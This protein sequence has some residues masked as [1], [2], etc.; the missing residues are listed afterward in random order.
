MNNS[1][2]NSNPQTTIEIPN[3]QITETVYSGS[4]TIVFRGICTNDQLPVVIKLLKNDYPTFSELVQFRNQYTIAKNLH[5][6]L[7]IQTYSLE[8]Y[9]NSYALVM[10][11]F[12]GISL[13]EWGLNRE[14]RPSLSEVLEIAITLCN[15]LEILYRERI[16]HKDIK[17]SNILINPETK[18]VKLI[19][20][21][22]ASLLPKE[23]QILINPNVLEGT[24]AYISPE[25]TG[26]M[27]R[28]IDY[29]TDFYSLGITF[30]KLLTGKLPFE[31]ND[32]MEL[33]HCHLAKIAPSINEINPKIPF[34]LSKIVS[35]LIAKNAESRYQSILG[36]KYD[37][38][39]CLSQLQQTGNIQDFEIARRD[40]SDR[41]LIPDKLYGR[42]TEITELLAA[43]ERVAVGNSEMT[44]VAGFSGIGKTAVVNE[45]HK[46]IVR[47]RGYFIKGK[48]DQFNHNIPFSAF[49]Q[50][51]RDLMGQLLSE[52]DEELA[53]WKA[54]ILAAVGD[55]GQVLIDVIPELEQVISQQS[56]ATEL[57]GSAAQNRF[58]LLFGKFVQLFTT[59][60]HPLVLFLDDLQWADSASLNLLKVLMGKSESGYLLVLGAY[61]DNEVFPAHPLMLTLDEIEQQ[62]ETLNTIVLKPL[63]RTQITHLVADTLVCSLEV[64]DPLGRLICQKTQGNP[65]FTTQFLKGLYE[66]ELIIF[67]SNLGYWQCDLVKVR[68][69][70]L[71]DDVVEFM[72]ERLLKFSNVTREVLKLAACIGNQFSLET[73]AVVY[74]SSEAEVAKALWEPL[75][76]G[77]LLPTNEI[78]KFYQSEKNTAGLSDIKDIKERSPGYKFLHDRVQQAAYSLI[79]E[80]QRQ[81]IHLT[82]G[83]LLQRNASIA[84]Q[85]ELIFEI[86]NQMNM[87]KQLVVVQEQ[88]NNLARLNLIA[89]K[90]SIAAT[91]YNAASRYSEVGI[92]M[93]GLDGWKSQYE[94]TLDLH[95][96]AAE[97]SYLDTKFEKINE[98]AEPVLKYAKKILEKTKIYEIQI[99][100]HSAQ[101]NIK[102]SAETGLKTLALLGIEFPKDST[103]INIYQELEKLSQKIEETNVDK[104]IDLPQMNDL[105]KLAAMR[106][107]STVAPS[108]YK[109]FPAIYPLIVFTQI[110]LS[111][112]YGNANLSA[113][114]YAAY[115]LILCAV[116]K[117]IEMGYKFGEIAN[118]MQTKLN[119]TELEAKISAIT[120]AYI[121]PWKEDIRVALPMF[122]SGYQSGLEAGDLEFGCYCAFFYCLHSYYL[123]KELSETEIIFHKYT[124]AIHHLRQGNT[125]SW[126]EIH[127]QTI[128]NLL[129]KSQDPCELKGQA[130]EEDILLPSIN[131]SDDRLLLHLL[132][133]NKLYLNY[134]FY[135]YEASLENADKAAQYLDGVTG[136]VTVAIFCFYDSLARLSCQLYSKKID[137]QS[138]LNQIDCNQRNMAVW[139]SHSPE[140]FQHK[141]HLVKAE[142]YR[143]QGNKTEAIEYYDRAIIGAKENEYI[144]EEALANELA[145]KFYLAWGKEKIAAVYMQEAYY[146][147]S[148]WGAKAKVNHLETTYPKLL[149]PILQQ[150]QFNLNTLETI[151]FHGT[152]SSTRTISTGSTSISDVLDFTSVLKAAQVLSSSLELDP[153]IASLSRIIIENSGAKKAALLL[154]QDD[155]WLIKAI[156]LITQGKI[157][158]TL[159]PQSLD[160]CSDIPLTVINYVKNTKQT[161]VIDNCQTDIP[162]LIGE[163]MLS[164]QPQS[165]LCT[166]IMN[167]GNLVGILYLENK[168]VSG[169]FTG[170]RL[171]VINLLSSQAAISLENA[172]LY[173]Q[174]QQSLQDL[175]Q[176]QLQLVQSEKMSAL[177]NLIAGV[178]HEIN[179][180]VGFIS[181]NVNEALTSVKDLTEFLQLYQEKIPN[182][183]DE[184]TEKAE[185]L[186]IEYLLEDLPKMLKSMQVG[187]DRIKGISTSLR[188]F[189]RADKDYKVPFNIHEGIDS[190][191]LILKHRLKANEKRP[192]IEVI[193]NYGDLPQVQCFPGQ[194]NQVFM[195]IIANAIDALD[196]SSIG[197]IFTEIEVNPNRITITTSVENQGVKIAICD[198]GHGM[199]QEVQARIFDHLFTTK[200]VGKGTGLGLAIALQ[201]ITEKHCGTIQ[202]NSILGKGT[203][204]T[205]TL[206]N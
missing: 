137:E 12:G 170:D 51:F 63:I 88:K 177:G 96:T 97:A 161:V 188:T 25:Q 110:D 121:K 109:I 83:E 14:N 26:R 139:A 130:Y 118:Q 28:G 171:S 60:E 201:I 140:N 55:N 30:Y 35:K 134:L 143:F 173:Q 52:S 46:P 141:Y 179:N 22:I 72:A 54:K 84:H 6:P 153:L 155:T 81:S 206:P 8:S 127:R 184:I 152:L 147:Y 23:T 114:A 123:G 128:L 18:E 56:P 99:L 50:A 138:L 111:I 57:S 73:L 27:N 95:I 115:G 189:S 98:F 180:P 149:Q 89:A 85:E 82:I 68:D 168:L 67:N 59:K 37:L 106:I 164:H 62:G 19:D 172:R 34:V 150:Q 200:G 92:E 71:T 4:R 194:L 174:A 126:N 108:I 116:K 100:S 167:Q 122:V 199:N 204:F 43:F 15:A 125:V 159:E 185:E 21:S 144:Q 135:Q 112:K 169:V 151:T 33:V 5:S 32:P 42:E 160:N 104:L 187:C 182:P 181:G 3:Y 76:D 198:N 75:Q 36:L 129:G 40:V 79:Q 94:I 205:I 162:G 44:L 1:H 195:N 103:Q 203:E 157:K 7:I 49:V 163:Y 78:Y 191:L 197:Q 24:L 45:V 146:C 53:N 175:Q 131:Q 11:D 77:F 193:T 87:G 176:A 9:Q 10:E 64:A 17:P 2:Q 31:S 61:R 91:A 70:A 166:A 178:G 154:P 120:G 190:T 74:E 107:L 102:A 133:T 13:Q 86:V 16:I 202:V 29:R 93:L 39:N 156:T 132:Y 90:K 145:A 105:E 20:F 142:Y 186:E 80:E 192:E 101:K 117:D 38:E 41:F 196:E 69:A 158:T 136:M 119:L 124:Q 148:R 165:V 48:F 65:F 47:Q 58:N 113:F 66:D 183:G